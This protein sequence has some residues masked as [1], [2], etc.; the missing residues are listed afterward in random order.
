MARPVEVKACQED[1][2]S[3]NNDSE[4]EP[5]ERPVKKVKTISEVGCRVEAERVAYIREVGE[6]IRLDESEEDK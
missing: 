5:V 6:I 2:D 3:D 4:D 1:D